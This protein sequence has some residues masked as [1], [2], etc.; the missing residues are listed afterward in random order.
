MEIIRTFERKFS[1]VVEMRKLTGLCNACK[2]TDYGMVN[3]NNKRDIEEV[4]QR[5]R[6]IHATTKK[7]C[8]ADIKIR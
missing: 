8:Y 6:S 4:S 2:W 5:L 7:E 3:P 1:N